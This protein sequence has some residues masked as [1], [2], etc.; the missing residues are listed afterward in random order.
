VRILDEP[1]EGLDPTR[2]G[3]IVELL[4]EEAARGVT[5]LLSSHHFGEIDRLCDHVVFLNAGRV[6]ADERAADVARRAR[7]FVRLT[8]PGEDAAALAEA[9][10][11]RLGAEGVVRA[12]RRTDARLATDD[13]RPFLAA[14]A[15]EPSLPVPESIE[16]GRTSLADLYRDLYGVGGL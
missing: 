8:W 16:H 12:G 1:T 3:R 10:L 7:H 4:R 13:P 11:G 2:R 14:L 6:L 15:R 5:I 9:A